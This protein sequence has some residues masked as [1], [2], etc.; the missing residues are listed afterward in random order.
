MAAESSRSLFR[1]NAVD[2]RGRR[3]DP[4]V[5]AAAEEIYPRAFE[6]GVRLLGDPAVVMNVLEEVAATTSRIIRA[7]DPPANLTR[8]SNLPGYVFTAFVRRVN[9]LKRRE[10][11][12]FEA[13]AA[14]TVSKPVWA[15]PSRQLE[16][17]ILFDEFLAQCD[18]IVEDM[19]C[20]YV[21]G[22]SWDEIGKVHG[23]S[24]HAAE[25]R[26]SHAIRQ[27]RARLKL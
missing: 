17:K 10:L 15:D 12:M 18:P 24:A 19:F 27:I 22:F 8:I 16:L 26:F 21:S 2:R 14:V 6:H 11:M 13:V 9:N 20:R 7:K 4:T 1:L 25:A 5:L 23:V 3:I